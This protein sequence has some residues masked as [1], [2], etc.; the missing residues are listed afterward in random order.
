MV[1]L[2]PSKQKVW[3]QL[4]GDMSDGESCHLTG[5]RW[6]RGRKRLAVPWMLYGPT[7]D[8]SPSACSY[9]RGGRGRQGG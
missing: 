2:A 7:N 9:Y 6:P 3:P 4:D 5:T 8:V 1:D